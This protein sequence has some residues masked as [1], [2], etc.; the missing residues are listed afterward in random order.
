MR[1]IIFRGKDSTGIMNHDWFYGSLDTSFNEDFPRI[2]CKD[3]WGNTM[4]ITVDCET[5][6]QYVGIKDI[7]DNNIYEGDIVEVYCN[8]VCNNQKRSQ[9]DVPT[10][11]RAV[12]KFGNFC[13]D[14]GFYLDYYNNFNNKI[15]QPIGREEDERHIWQRPL[16][17][18]DFSIR[19]RE[20]HENWLWKNHIE[21]IGNVHDN[22]E[23]IQGECQ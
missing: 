1:D 6:G 11:V 12:V 20:T 19:K 17:D 8:R 4:L 15:C 13:H 18:F 3:K 10:K 22:P 2:I 5:V 7:N 21:V 16:G 14:I 23:L 9:Y